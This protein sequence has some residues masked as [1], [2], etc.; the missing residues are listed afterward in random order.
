MRDF[1]AFGIERVVGDDFVL[2][3]SGNDYLTAGDGN[4]RLF[5][6]DGDDDNLSEGEGEEEKAVSDQLQKSYTTATEAS[7]RYSRKL[8]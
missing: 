6:G 3:G 8:A 2:G 5:G 1:F 4:D 7:R